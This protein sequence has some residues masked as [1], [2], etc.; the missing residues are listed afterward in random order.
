MPVTD[1]DVVYVVPSNFQKMTVTP[2][3]LLAAMLERQGLKRSDLAKL[4]NV[5]WPTVDRWVQNEGFSRKN[6]VNAAVALGLQP[7]TFEV[8]DLTIAHREKCADVLREFLSS[9]LAPKDVTEEERAS[10]R[11]QQIPLHLQPTIY[12]FSGLLLL[13]RGQ[14]DPANFEAEVAENEQLSRSV[15]QKK[16]E[17]Q[18][19][20]VEAEKTRKEKSSKRK[21]RKSE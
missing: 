10:L 7:D 15:A 9:P 3:E 11:S 17:I 5:N 4:V 13:L 12:F 2:G 21:K 19:L 18:R 6:R 14:L 8:P 16:E 20:A 1:M